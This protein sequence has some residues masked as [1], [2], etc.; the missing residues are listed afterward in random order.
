MFEMK[1]VDIDTCILCH[2][3]SF[4]YDEPFSRKPKLNLPDNC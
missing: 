1:V 2:I 4:L 3:Q